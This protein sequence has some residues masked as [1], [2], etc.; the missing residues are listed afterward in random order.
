M[1]TDTLQ[2]PTTEAQ[3]EWVLHVAHVLGAKEPALTVSKVEVREPSC[4]DA[5][6]TEDV[7]TEKARRERRRVLILPREHG[8]W[9]LLL[10]PLVTGAGIALRGSSNVFPLVLLVTTALILFWLRTPVES[11]LGTSP[12]RV[13]T[14]EEFRDVLFVAG[15]LSIV[16]A[17]A[18]GMLL[19][20]GRNPLLWWIG[21]AAGVAFAAQAVIKKLGRN[22]RMLSEIVG[23]IGLTA[24][25]PAAYYVVTGKF[26][27]TAWMLWLAN[28]LFAGDQ[29]HY[30]QLR[31][32][33]AR[34]EGFRA[35]LRRGWAFAVGQA[36]MTTAITM[37]CVTGLMPVIASLAFSPLLFRGWYYFVQESKPLVVR[38]LGWNELAQ[39]VVFCVVFIAA[40]AATR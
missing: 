4:F 40:F 20:S 28:L 10:V 8:A 1:P 22:A 32:H 21:A 26:G 34:V 7:A 19:W 5:D 9:G 29:I 17:L 30:V 36:V 3:K 15:Y 38:R 31:I 25:A 37:A 18:L 11:L 16:A 2:E 12:I 6:R 24:S 13:Q 14:D 39:A 27:P 33:T 35:K 23:I